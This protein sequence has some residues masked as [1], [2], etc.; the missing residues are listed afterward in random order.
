[1]SR[2]IDLA[3]QRFGRLVVLR[4]AGSTPTGKAL[5]LCR[6]DCGTEKAVTG[7]ALRMTRKPVRSCGCAMH[8]AGPRRDI[9]GRVFGRLTA[10]RVEA[11]PRPGKTRWV[12]RC[13]CGAE[14]SVTVDHLT[15]GHTTSCGCW[16]EERRFKHGHAK[17]NATTGTY[18]SWKAMLRRCHDPKNPG[19]ELYGGRGVRVCDR[20]NP[21]EGGCFANFLADM[22]PRPEGLELDK[23]TRAGAGCLLYSPDTCCWATKEEQV[24]AMR[25]NRWVTH[26][27]QTLIASDLARK[28]GLHPDVFTHRLDAGWDVQRALDTPVG[29]Y[30][31]PPGLAAA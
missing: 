7:V 20:W 19:W 25:S 11:P 30:V 26:E 9:T 2:S 29:P 12:C 16:Q 3:G 28:A 22:G 14:C 31:R 24:R 21:S 27:G 17:R 5:W 4:R 10:V 15:T 23:D 8:Q 1:M 6:C 18:G 13:C